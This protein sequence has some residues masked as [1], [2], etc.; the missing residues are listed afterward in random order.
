MMEL[1]SK[2]KIKEDRPVWLINLPDNCRSLFDSLE[3]KEKPGRTKP[4]PQ[5]IIFATDSKILTHELNRLTEYIGHDTLLWLCYPK[6]TGAIKSDLVMME[7]WNMVFELG[8]RGQTS[9]S[10]NNDW[11]GLRVTNAPRK[12]PSPADVPMAERKADG[13]DFVN[14]TVTLPAD[15]QAAINKY[16]G[17][18][19]FFTAMAFT[20]K[21]EYVMAITD[22]KKEETRIRRIAQMVEMLQQKMHAKA[23]KV[24]K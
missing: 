23:A 10:I 19:E 18:P 14:R 7:S 16:K 1:L 3:I 20:H 17:M 2:L 5:V 8:Y 22:A 9:V 6:K 15:A 13:I 11:T 24:K 4:L 12:K 21:K